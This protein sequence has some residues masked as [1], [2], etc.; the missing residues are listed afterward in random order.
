MSAG[1]RVKF[2]G[3]TAESFQE[4]ICVSQLVKCTDSESLW[5]GFLA[6]V[7]CNREHSVVGSMRGVISVSMCKEA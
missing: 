3:Q 4:L 2:L 5:F 6:E 1:R 7:S